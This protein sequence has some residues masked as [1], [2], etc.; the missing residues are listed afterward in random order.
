MR[1]FTFLLSIALLFIVPFNTV[2]AF[3][4][5]VSPENQYYNSIKTLYDEGL[6][7]KTDSF[8]PNDTLKNAELYEILIDFSKTKLTDTTTTLPY[9]DIPADSQYAKYIQTALEIGIIKAAG[10]NNKFEPNK[11]LSKFKVLETMFRTL[12]IGTNF[13]FDRQK[14]AFT[15]IN[16]N[17]GLAPIAQKASEIGI[18]ESSNP[19]SFKMAK[20]ITR[21]E[22][23]D[24]LY[25]IKQ[26]KNLGTVQ[27]TYSFELPQA[28]NSTSQNSD[29]EKELLDNPSFD[30]LLDVWK[31]LKQDYLYK[32]TLDNSKLVLGAIEGM[33]NQAGDTYTVFEKPGEDTILESL[34][35]EYEGIG[36]SIEMIDNKITVVSPL[37]DSPAEKA[38]IKPGDVITAVDGESMIGKKLSDVVTKIKG[39]A[40]TN[41]KITITRDG[42]EQNYTITRSAL[43]YA[44]VSNEFV[45]VGTKKIAHLELRSFND[46]TFAE[47]EKTAKDIVDQ[48]ADG[49]ILDLRNNPGGYMDV[50][51]GIIGLFT[52]KEKT[53]VKVKFSDNS[54]QSFKT[55]KNGLLKDIKTVVLINA[56][57]A[58][59]S[60]IL[61]GALQ[62]YKIV[63]LIG[64]KSFGKGTVQDI[65]AYRNGA[66]L[67]YTTA[68]WM[69]PNGRDINKK[70]LTPEKIVKKP[71]TVDTQL[72]A[73]LEEF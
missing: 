3:Y 54:V 17:S 12:D 21:G 72:N 63:K 31:T 68:R 49:L 51:I 35:S 29:V 15:D 36:I 61:A 43:F 37:K 6:L 1:K 16:K 14:F 65:Q 25:K 55:N 8:R 11:S 62:D 70:G 20:R 28:T 2:Y 46:D 18:T 42:K 56:G 60:E 50:A 69:T 24:Y 13:F 27:I 4:N 71:G 33:V 53:A 67:K 22:T 41:V 58:S 40:G 44:T 30:I 23:A 48:K 26:Y 9:E 19:K 38:G 32:D 45:E 7:P 34:S 73:A 57:S 39:P 64:E 47:F 66:I 10:T 5:D 52:D 59:A